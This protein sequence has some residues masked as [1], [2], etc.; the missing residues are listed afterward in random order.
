MVHER[1]AGLARR[2]AAPDLIVD[3]GG[4]ATLL[5]HK[6]Y[7]FE[8]AGAVPAFD[9]ERDPEEWGVILD[10]LR[11]VRQRDPGQWQ[12]IG[13]PSGAS[14]RKRRPGSTGSTR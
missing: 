5:V 6:G 13:R 3:D 8:R 14:A 4:D 9:P 7:E 2:A 1:G 11:D 12:R 10:L